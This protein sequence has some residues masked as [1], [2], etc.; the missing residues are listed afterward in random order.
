[1]ARTRARDGLRRIPGTI[2]VLLTTL[3]LF[4]LEHWLG[5]GTDLGAQIRL[6]ALRADRISDHG[7]IWRLVTPIFLHHGAIHLVLNLFALLQLGP[8][9][10]SMWGT[11]RF[12]AFYVAC[13][14]AGSLASASLT[15]EIYAGSVGSS[16]ALMGLAGLLLGTRAYGEEHAR[17]F[18]G[19][20]LGR[21]LLQGVLL[22]LG[23]GFALYLLLPVVDNWAHI[24]GLCC[25]LL[26]AAAHGDP[27]EKS[28]FQSS[29][30][31][32]A[33][34]LVLSSS[35][36]AAAAQGD[37]AL[38][39]L[40]IDTARMLSARASQSHEAVGPLLLPEMLDWY[41]RAQL[42]PDGS[43]PDARAEGLDRFARAVRAIHDPSAARQLTGVLA[44]AEREGVDREE[45]LMLVLQRWYEI[46]PEDPD[47]LNGLAWQ[48]VTR[49]ATS[50]R[51]P[52]RALPLSR[53]S[54]R[55]IP[56]P[57]SE[58]GK[59]SRAAYLDTLAEILFQLGELDE[60]LKSQQEAIS[61]GKEAG[62]TEQG[63]LTERLAKIEEAIAARGN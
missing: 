55:R 39:T 61:L 63:E 44:L 47:A 41:D 59:L 46:A 54:L 8:L 4:G 13:G 34:M 48:L 52:A 31:A 26:L 6:G 9:V 24:G 53:E 60:A 14:I 45:H 38:A 2:F 11:R 27:T 30:G 37:R 23:L 3:F 36:L 56:D 51:D 7:E 33:A 19:E 22:T 20:V 18:L 43:V 40:E 57:S 12:F 35:L 17:D 42:R 25:G 29:M 15:S 49:K 58:Q 21:R 32:L 5:G 28:E 62:M 10:E 50:L 1:M 16:G